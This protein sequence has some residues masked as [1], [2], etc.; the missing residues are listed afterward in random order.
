VESRIKF[1]VISDTGPTFVK[2]GLTLWNT[3]SVH[4]KP[5]QLKTKVTKPAKK[6]F[7]DVQSEGNYCRYIANE[8]NNLSKSDFELYEDTEVWEIF[9]G[10]ETELIG[11]LLLIVVIQAVVI[12]TILS[13]KQYN[14]KETI[15]LSNGSVHSSALKTSE[16][17]LF[18]DRP[19]E[20]LRP[21]Y[22][23]NTIDSNDTGHNL[24]FSEERPE[25]GIQSK[26]KEGKAKVAQE[27]FAISSQEESEP[28]ATTQTPNKITQSVTK[29]TVK[30]R[31]RQ[32]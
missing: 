7:S 11:F 13:R 32:N 10:F 14:K 15:K 1:T 5:H 3:N 17:N 19:L 20:L 12:I 31:K 27:D 30:K 9:F 28:E 24:C 16:E 8:I 29:T 18:V 22:R 26:V 2:C 21:N 4:W 6:T 23:L 25:R